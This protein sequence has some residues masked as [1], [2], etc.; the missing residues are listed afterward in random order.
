MK[1]KIKEK[2][3]E[4]NPIWNWMSEDARN[5]IGSKV[6]LFNSPDGK[7]AII[8][9]LINIDTSTKAYH[10]FISSSKSLYD[11]T[12]GRR[13]RN[14]KFMYMASIT[15]N[16][17]PRARA[18]EL[19]RYTLYTSEFCYLLEKRLVLI[20]QLEKETEKA[21]TAKKQLGNL[22]EQIIEKTKEC[23][24]LLAHKEVL[25]QQF[26]E[27]EK[28]IHFYSVMVHKSRILH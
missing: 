18:S 16:P 28:K 20:E 13:A 3:Y 10:H 27:I 21:D 23:N 2:Q 1:F 17:V 7:D 24:N 15:S 11:T 14:R 6:I 8:A 19:G 9:K 4:G 25:K 5:L 26:E 12:N 22:H